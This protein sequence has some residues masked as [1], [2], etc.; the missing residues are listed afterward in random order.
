MKRSVLVFGWIGI[1]ASL[2]EALP[3]QDADAP[4]PI[5]DRACLFLD[6][7]FLAEQQGFT[8]TWHQGQPRPDVAVKE[9]GN[10]WERWPHMFGSTL[11][12]PESQ[13][14]RMYYESAISPSRTPPNSFTTY[15]CYAE[16]QDG[17]TWTKPVLGLFDDLG[18]KNNNIV[19]HCA[20]FPKVFLDPL[21][22]DPAARL[23][24]FVY[25][26]GRPP[27]HGGL[28]ECL[29]ASGDGLHWKFLGGFNKPEYAQADQGNFT[30]SFCFLYDPLQQRYMAYIRTFDKNRLAESKDG[31]RR[32]VGISHS[33][34]VNQDWSPIVQVLAPDADDD[35]KVAALSKDPDRPD[36]AEHYCMPFF[37]YGNH[38]LGML[39]LLYLV[40]GAD[41]NGGGDLQLT[42][43]HDGD[44]WFRQP[45]RQSLIAPS[46]AAPDLFPTYVSING[47]VEIGDELWLYYTEANG[48]H[49]L[50]PFE[51]A[52]SQIRAAVWRKDGFVSL[53][54]ADAAVLTTKPLTFT[55][56]RLVVNLKC[57]EGGR[58]RAAVL[59]VDGKPL[60]GF[61][62]KD[63][64]P[65]TGDQLHGVV[66]WNGR[67]DLSAINDRP[68]RLKL[69]VSRGSLY[70][71]R[72]GLK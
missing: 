18:S 5:R 11:Y 67:P 50:A 7:R 39:S 14:Y 60:P 71:I 58:L 52:R 37:V 12:D 25:L 29:L 66:Q 32:A 1:L 48:A 24:M 63:C 57:A 68:V 30:D 44:T 36:W 20:E 53:D 28:G 49:P 6:D 51:K 8:R 55:G 3:A 17:K 62:L 9:D 34:K 38:Y 10:P 21:E 40:D 16:S 23:K 64:V 19:I 26:N 35:A 41:S 43:S 72:V 54:A 33:R 2:P 42:F 46:P 15:V 27:L 4:I 31:R 65:L 70:S 61:D 47:P 56:D 59:T 69:E 22:K 13:R 45:Q